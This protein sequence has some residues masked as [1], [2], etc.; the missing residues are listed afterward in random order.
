MT[1]VKHPLSIFS[2]TCSGLT[3]AEVSRS[4]SI[5]R[6]VDHSLASTVLN[7]VKVIKKGFD[8]KREVASIRGH[9]QD[10]TLQTVTYLR[11]QS[12]LFPPIHMLLLSSYQPLAGIC[13]V[14]GMW[15]ISP[16]AAG[17]T[18][19]WIWEQDRCLTDGLLKKLPKWCGYSKIRTW[20]FPLIK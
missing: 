12:N 6:L 2:T 19:S 1:A 4:W 8:R 11:P 5:N 10:L 13:S 14:H 9:K 20:N 15:C 18:H 3:E 17:R 7:Q 16:Q